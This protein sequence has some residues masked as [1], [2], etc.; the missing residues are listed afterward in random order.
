MLK[1]DLEQIYWL[2]KELIL[3]Q[4]RRE[5]L[6]A[7]IAPPIKQLTGMPFSKTNATNAPTE[8]KAIKLAE[9]CKAIDRKITEIQIAIAEVEK[10]ILS[11]DD[12]YIRQ[13]L[14]YRCVKLMKWEEVAKKMGAGYTSE[15]VRTSYHRF[16]KNLEDRE[17]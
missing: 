2:Q 4:E 16:V 17:E 15:A 8:E 6:E 11:I 5:E 7:D 12:A 9:C 13:I 10:Y 3:W 1:R 14:E